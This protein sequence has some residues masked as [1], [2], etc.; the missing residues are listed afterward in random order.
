VK[1]SVASILELPNKSILLST[2]EGSVFKI[3]FHG[4]QEA[5]LHETCILTA[6]SSRIYDI[7]FPTGCSELFA[8]ASETDVRVWN[9]ATRKE[10][11]RIAIPKVNCRAVIFKHDGS[12]ILTGTGQDARSTVEYQSSLGLF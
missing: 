8:C 6:H 3:E 2:T 10:L 9:V 11:L 7:A 12:S 5:A 4:G 1:G